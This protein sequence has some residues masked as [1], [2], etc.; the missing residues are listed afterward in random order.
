MHSR[1]ELSRTL[2]GDSDVA[3]V[4]TRLRQEIASLRALSPTD[5]TAPLLVITPGDLRLGPSVETDAARFL[6][7]CAAAPSQTALEAKASI[8]REACELYQSALLSEYDA[9]WIVAERHRFDILHQQAVHALAVTLLDLRDDTGAE[10][11]LHRLLARNPLQEETHIALMRLYA[12]RGQPLRVR[13][14]FQELERALEAEGDPGPAEETSL[15]AETLSEE[16]KRRATGMPPPS[17][18]S[19]LEEVTEPSQP[20]AHAHGAE[21]EALQHSEPARAARAA[22]PTVPAAKGRA[23]FLAALLPLLIVACSAGIWYWKAFRSARISTA[24]AP[25][26]VADL[27]LQW[28]FLYQPLP[29]ERPNAEGR[30]V[31]ADKTGIYATG[32]I[33][34]EKEDKDILTLKLSRAGRLIWA[35]RYSSPENDCDRASSICVGERGDVY[36]GGETYVPE[37]GG[38]SGAWYLTLLHYDTE[39]RSDRVWWRRSTLQ[40]Q[41]AAQCVQVL[42]DRHGGCYI[43]GTALA[44]S[45]H[46]ILMLRFDRSGR[47]MWEKTLREGTDTTFG[48]AVCNSDG[49]LFICGTA[50]PAAAPGKIMDEWI[51][52]ALDPAGSVRWRQTLD[53]PAHRGG[54][55]GQIALSDFGSVL[56]VGVFD[57]GDVAR[58]GHGQNLA[59]GVFSPDDGTYRDPLPAENTGPAVGGSGLGGNRLGDVVLGG[60]LQQP[61]GNSKAIFVKY[62]RAG[63]LVRNWSYPLPSGYRSSNVQVTG[64]DNGAEVEFLGQIT[65]GNAFAMHI[66]S[67]IVCGAFSPDGS[68]ARQALYR[69]RP[70]RPTRANSETSAF[71]NYRAVVGQAGLGNDHMG[72]LVLLY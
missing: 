48:Q 6:A 66:D 5:D 11:A 70:G 68:L 18:V 16:G 51:V 58:G 38:H 4:R 14:Q 24:A 43:C 21:Q 25:A 13:Q 72:F 34:T 59:L 9:V 35:R 71:R 52:A 54:G 57:T 32:L 15:L 63:N 36:V 29:G 8:L 67:A 22:E 44:G 20:T 60:T 41:N 37:P 27:P 10:E 39:N 3:N 28:S 19:A 45:K 26:R 30:A 62:D 17:Q 33:D 23:R 55:A 12:N 50:R 49:T 64:I 65:R 40:V 56:V 47:R 1:S 61:D 42:S 69:A 2:W 46:S 53:G 31:A 7:C